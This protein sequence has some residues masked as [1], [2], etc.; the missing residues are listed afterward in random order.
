MVDQR[1]R[2]IFGKAFNINP[3]S[4]NSEMN[5]DSIKEWDSLGHITL[6]LEIEENFG[7]KF[8]SEKIIE[9]T[10]VNKI[11]EILKSMGKIEN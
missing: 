2:Q 1:L 10:A 6:I 11:E 3:D 7:V 8:P 5:S 4:V 9:L